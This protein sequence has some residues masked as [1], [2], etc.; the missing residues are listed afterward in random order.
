[1]E[2]PLH[3][4]VCK[5]GPALAAG[6]TLIIKPS[7]VAPTA[8]FLLLD[9]VH[10]A[11]LPA[12]VVNLV[13]GYGPV[14]GEALASHPDVDMVSFT[15]SVAAG[16]RVAELAA[17]T[18]KKTTLELGGKS[19]NV[20]LDDADL[21]TAVKVG[22]A[23]AFLNGGQTCTAWTRM[24]VPADRQAEAL[25]IAAGVARTYRPGDPMDP[26]TK[27]GPLVSGRQRERVRGF[28]G[29]GR[30]QGARLVTG[31]AAPPEGL[32]RGY[33]VRPTIFGDVDP[34]A[35]IAQEE[36]FGPVLSVIPYR[37][38]DHALEVANNS[39][40]GLHGAVWSADRSRAL[41]FARQVRTG[42]ID[43][44]GGAYNPYAPFGGYKKSGL[45]RE[46]GRYGL[47]EFFEIKSIQL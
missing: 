16:S 2:L 5:L 23:N 30:E 37:D 39:S 25:K 20:I 14:V 7:E 46:M 17:K 41:A 44:N 24:L 34:D 11:G 38:E 42:T 10:Q 33:Y 8:A 6:C 18:L 22:V 26:E 19:A 35:S 29:Q 32:E 36:I 27:L 45:G 40:F 47:E 4:I 13:S 15:G 9:A 12:G 3:Q 43:I 1:M 31:G 28:I 21:K